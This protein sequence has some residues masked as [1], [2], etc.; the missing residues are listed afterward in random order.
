MQ[1]KESLHWILDKD[2]KSSGLKDQ[3]EKFKANIDFV[4][5]LGLKCDCV[6]W[7]RMDLGRP[8]IGELLAKIEDFCRRER[9][10]VRAWYDRTFAGESDWFALKTTEFKENASANRFYAPGRDGGEVFLERIKAYADL[11]PGPREIPNFVAVPERFRDICIKQNIPCDFFWVE[12]RGKWAGTQYFCVVPHHSVPRATLLNGNDPGMAEK[13][14][15]MLPRVRELCYQLDGIDLPQVYL[16][17]DLPESGIVCACVFDR[18]YGEFMWPRIL[19]HRDTAELLIKERALSW[20]QLEPVPVMDEFPAGYAVRETTPLRLPTEDYIK[21][22]MAQYEALKANPRP[23][24]LVSE[25]DALKLLRA[26]KKDRKA[27]FSK[28]LTKL[29]SDSPVAPYWK[30]AGSGYLS[31]EYELLSPLTAGPRTVEF[32]MAMEREELLETKPEG[33]MIAVCPDGDKCLLT[34]A[35]TVER[36]SHEA[37]EV[38]ES[39]PTLAQFI[40]DALQD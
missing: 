26:A 14:G 33:R 16:R 4:H 9:W 27:D 29:E 28:G 11:T 10:G 1:Y 18:R 22:G 5:A 23:V 12:D 32:L 31:D 3:D 2:C 30:V 6:G 17:R 37:P 36:W 25:K 34:P 13:L 40:A 19:V 20:K 38:T 21:K 24:R 15:G 8:D 39:W 7:C 35:G